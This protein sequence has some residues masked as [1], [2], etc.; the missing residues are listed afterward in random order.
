MSPSLRIGVSAEPRLPE[1]NLGGVAPSRLIQI[2]GRPVAN[3]TAP[4]LR[5]GI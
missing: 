2:N 5:D 1:A 3:A 4:P